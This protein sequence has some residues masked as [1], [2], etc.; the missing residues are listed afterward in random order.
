MCFL[1]FK[2]KNINKTSDCSLIFCDCGSF[3]KRLRLRPASHSLNS[4]SKCC[5]KERSRSVYRNTLSL[6]LTKSTLCLEDI[7]LK[8]IF[9]PL[10]ELLYNLK[11]KRSRSFKRAALCSSKQ[12]L[13]FLTILAH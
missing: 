3:H 13:R 4:S 10:C 7:I 12:K 5:H 8:K 11:N 2:G 9:V 1:G 6:N